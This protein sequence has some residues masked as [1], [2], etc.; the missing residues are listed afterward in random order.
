MAQEEFGPYRLETL[1]GRGGMGEVFRAY[2]TVRKRT[3]ALKRLPQELG[4]DSAF[5]SR[6]RRESELAAR[7]SEPHIIP[8][9]DY[10][11]IDGQLFIVMPLVDGVDLATLLA[12]DGPLPP[13][14]AVD[15]ISQVAQALDAAHANGLVHRD[16]KPS[17]VLIAHGPRHDRDFVYLVDFGIARTTNVGGTSLT[18]TGSAVGTLDYMA[19]ERFTGRS[20]DLRVDVYSLGCLLYETLTGDKPFTGE[21]LPALMH[22]HLNVPPPAPSRRRPMLPPALDEV[23]ARGMAKDPDDRYPSAAR[24][25]AAARAALGSLPRDIGKVSAPPTISLTT[26][27]NGAVAA[28]PA[29][30]PT[31]PTEP[32]PS[33]RDDHPLTDSRRFSRVGSAISLVLGPALLTAGSL[34]LLDFPDPDRDPSVFLEFVGSHTARHQVAALVTVLGLLVSL[35]GLTG[36]AHFLRGPRLTVGQ[37]GAALMIVSTFLGNSYAFEVVIGVAT[38]SGVD[39]DQVITL[40]SSAGSSGWLSVLR[41]AM[42]GSVL[43]LILLAVDLVLRRATGLWVPILLAVA[44]IERTVVAE[45]GLAVS[46]RTLAVLDMVLFAIP[47]AGLAARML[48]MTDEEWGRW[49][50][51]DSPPTAAGDE[52]AEERA[53]AASD[54]ADARIR[55]SA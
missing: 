51:L 45:A 16:V 1:I 36:L 23:V 50:P 44:A 42:L 30:A 21:S 33:P 7:V 55:G 10:G 6:F 38:R 24:L 49:M 52:P 40:L 28:R 48:R 22:R 32:P 41:L 27:P 15:I 19:P 17:N 34:L 11:E 43:S 31:A 18:A 12:D 25:A 13:A 9:H 4:A 20:D 29:T 5:Q 46:Q 8:I 53:A 54:P 2:D 47:A 35:W 26:A 14:R 37:L 39:R 3:V